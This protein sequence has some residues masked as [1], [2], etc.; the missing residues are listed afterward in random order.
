MYTSRIFENICRQYLRI[1]NRKNALPF[2]STKIGC[3]WDNKNE[4]DIMATDSKHQT[5]LLA[6]CKYRNTTMTL[7]DLTALQ[8]KFH[9]KDLNAK[10]Y[11]WLFSKSGFTEEVMNAANNEGIVTVDAKEVVKN[12]RTL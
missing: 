4:I 2:Y 12:R 6:E 7:S 5:F 11:Y 10:V 8:E 1:Q 9:P 3:W